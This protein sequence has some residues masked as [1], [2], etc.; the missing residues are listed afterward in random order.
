ARTLHQELD[1]PHLY[2][3][4]VVSEL[5]VDAD[6]VDSLTDERRCRRLA[7]APEAQ[8]EDAIRQ[9]RRHRKTRSRSGEPGPKAASANRSGSGTTSA[10]PIWYQR[11]GSRR[12]PSRASRL[13]AEG[14]RTITSPSAPARSSA[15]PTRRGSTPSTR[16]M[17]IPLGR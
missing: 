15:S 12:R 5:S 10:S 17:L 2:E 3:V 6:D 8:H 4:L 11:R 16:T 1:A 7:G 13:P 14:S 9:M